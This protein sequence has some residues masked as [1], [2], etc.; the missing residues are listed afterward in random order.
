MSAPERLL[1]YYA[2]PKLYISVNS[3]PVV[4]LAVKNSGATVRRAKYMSRRSFVRSRL[5][6]HNLRKFVKNWSSVRGIN[7]N[8][9]LLWDYIGLVIYLFWQLC[10]VVWQAIVLKPLDH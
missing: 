9:E 10:E 2:Y 3:W 4:S 5:Y 1:S 8:L 7:T 6:L